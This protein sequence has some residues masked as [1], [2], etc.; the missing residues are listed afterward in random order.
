MA[1]RVNPV[2]RLARRVGH[3]GSCLLFFALVDLVYSLSLF[4]PPSQAR[5]SPVL[6]FIAQVM[7]LNA[8]ALLWLICGIACLIGAF[9]RADTWAFVTA[10]ALKSLWGLTLLLG[11]I[12]VDLERG[13]VSAA[14]WLGMAGWVY[15]ISSWPEPPIEARPEVS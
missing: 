8:W 13:W 9:Q 4:K 15:I 10:V 5:L 7:P 1:G 6:G 12:L 11:W 14:I 3:R 2:T